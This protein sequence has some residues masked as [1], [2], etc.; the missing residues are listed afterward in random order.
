[1][2][3]PSPKVVIYFRMFGPYILSRLSAASQ[4]NN[5]FAIEGGS[6][7]AI[8]NW[9]PRESRAFESVTLFPESMIETI[10]GSRIAQALWRLMEKIQPDVVVIGG[11]AFVESLTMLQWAR[12]RGIPVIV[13][14]ESTL[15]DRS[16]NFWVEEVKRLIIKSC[17]S[18]LVGGSMSCQYMV[19]LGM[20]SN[21]TF[22]G[23]DAVDNAYFSQNANVARSRAREWREKLDLPSNF[24]LACCRFVPQKN[25]AR[26]LQAYAA[27]HRL[28]G[29]R[30]W[31]L[32][33]VGD[34]PERKNLERAVKKMGLQKNVRF[35]GFQQYEMLPYYYGLAQVFVHVSTIEPWG[36]VLNEALASELPVI[37]SNC[38]GA[39]A[40]LIVDGVN[41]LVV[42]PQNTHQITLALKKA[43]SGE[44]DLRAMGR[45]G[46]HRVSGW[47]PAKFAEGLRQAV[48]AAQRMR[49][50]PSTYRENLLLSMLQSAFKYTHLGW[51]RR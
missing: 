39:T 40:D 10:H 41:G 49:V 17:N 3:R 27:Y 12:K 9:E 46:S 34:G 23:Y 25:L 15:R 37:A 21:R 24:F 35:A 38:C 31:N 18:A 13:M 47:A 32:V 51:A 26:L 6:R 43:S 28:V 2:N 20:P 29:E 45:A 5:I 7:S 42:D 16:R 1:M 33:L 44:L 22:V 48:D 14:S 36:L 30:A 50:R 4:I 11:W 8:Y 19:S